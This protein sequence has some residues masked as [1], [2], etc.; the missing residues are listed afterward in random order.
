MKGG[1][2]YICGNPPY[3]GGR[4][5]DKE[6]QDDLAAL[7]SGVRLV[8]KTLD[9]VAAWYLKAA[10]YLHAVP[11]CSCAFVA[12]KSICQG[13]QVAMLWPL[14]FGQGLEISF[15]HRPFHWNSIAAANAGVTVVIV[16]IASAVASKSSSSRGEV[17]T[18]DSIGPYL[19]PVRSI[20]RREGAPPL[21][22]PPTDGLRE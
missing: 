5:R 19:I 1:E 14:V 13:E 15:A 6:Q 20:H 9:Y 17:R 11:G 12:T 21:E 8:S 7:F 4:W 22:R 2:T 16:G 10:D 3:L 18:V